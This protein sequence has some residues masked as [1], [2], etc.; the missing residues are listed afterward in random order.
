MNLDTDTLEKQYYEH[1]QKLKNQNQA[2]IIEQ[3]Q[4]FDDCQKKVQEI[5]KL[6]IKFKHSQKIREGSPDYHEF[7][8]FLQLNDQLQ[9][10]KNICL[11]CWTFVSLQ[12]TM[13]HINLLKHTII[14][15]DK[16]SDIDRFIQLA[17]DHE[18][19][20]V[21]DDLTLTVI[22]PPSTPK[23]VDQINQE[24]PHNGPTT[25][26]E[27]LN[28]NSN[29][30][31]KGDRMDEELKLFRQ[32][33][34]VGANTMRDEEQNSALGSL[35]LDEKEA[36]KLP[37]NMP[38]FDPT[39]DLNRKKQYIG[40]PCPPGHP[41][42]PFGEDREYF[43]ERVEGA[44][45]FAPP[46]ER[47]PHFFENFGRDEKFYKE[48]KALLDLGETNGNL[49]M[50]RLNKKFDIFL[51]RFMKVE[52]DIK[53]IKNNFFR[54]MHCAF[55]KYEEGFK[56]KNEYLE[57]RRVRKREEI[58]RGVQRELEKRKIDQLA[59]EAAVMDQTPEVSEGEEEEEVEAENMDERKFMR[60]MEV[61]D[62]REQ[63][64]YEEQE[65]QDREKKRLKA[66]LAKTRHL[67]ELNER[68]VPLPIPLPKKNKKKEKKRIKK[69]K[70]KLKELK[71]MQVK[72]VFPNLPA[73]SSSRINRSEASSMLNSEM[74]SQ[75]SHASKSSESNIIKTNSK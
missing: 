70:K 71:L 35:L 38:N 4:E 21:N 29:V 24:A 34:G 39:L 48:A 58:E 67:L 8:R 14:Y 57:R 23:S 53:E 63:E 47:D 18:R 51:K 19:I 12:Q 40:P 68:G 28:Q 73:R 42:D 16:F 44:A 33:I 31:H 13:D 56:R 50:I 2:A 49:E 45:L 60:K 1:Q 55:A 10:P 43:K 15:Q 6:L 32:H 26:A 22:T 54:V 75:E 20:I 74:P 69:E 37:P 27:Y 41:Y 25:V 7:S 17:R 59:T 3:D 62:K 30:L 5:R 72:P 52:E 46:E 65:K 36:H 61:Q 64:A 66:Q 9:T 11:H